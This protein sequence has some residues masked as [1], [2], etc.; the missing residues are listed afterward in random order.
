M[1][2][3]LQQTAKKLENQIKSDKVEK[4]LQRRQTQDELIQKGIMK[5]GVM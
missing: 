4:K 5:Q 1:S 3:Q 2:N